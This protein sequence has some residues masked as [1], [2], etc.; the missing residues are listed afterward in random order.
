[1]SEKLDEYFFK[2]GCFIEEWQ[3]DSA[4]P[5]MSIARVR[6]QAKQTT[7][8]HSLKNTCERY[9]ILSG[10]AMVTVGEKSWNVAPKD[11]VTIAPDQPQKINNFTDDDLVFLAVCT[12]RFRPEN[13]LDLEIEK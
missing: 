1:M 4:F 9:V 2:E 10:H 5:D 7:K 3:N 11:V 13:Y 8:L 6:V 12:P